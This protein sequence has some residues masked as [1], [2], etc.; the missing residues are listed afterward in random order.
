MDFNQRLALELACGAKCG[1]VRR[2]ARTKDG[3]MLSYR[4]SGLG[5]VTATSHALTVHYARIP[6]EAPI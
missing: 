5:A 3:L 2:N 1:G 6:I 4:P